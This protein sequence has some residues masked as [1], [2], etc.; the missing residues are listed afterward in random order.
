MMYPTVEL[1]RV[2]VDTRMSTLTA[3]HQFYTYINH[4]QWL[5]K[6]CTKNFVQEQCIEQGNHHFLI[7]TSHAIPL[8]PCAVIIHI[9]SYPRSQLQGQLNMIKTYLDGEVKHE[10]VR[11]FTGQFV[12]EVTPCGVLNHLREPRGRLQH[13]FPWQHIHCS[14]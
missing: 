5:I 1:L 6:M 9:K 12:E 3:L 13:Q 4:K 8:N 14:M 10:T 11:V 7:A 2:R